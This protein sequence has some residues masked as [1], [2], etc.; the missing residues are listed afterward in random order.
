MTAP[1]PDLFTRHSLPKDA[2]A[3][4]KVEE[5]FSVAGRVVAGPAC[6]IDSP[7]SCLAFVHALARAPYN[8]TRVNALINN[9]SIQAPGP[10][11]TDDADEALTNDDLASIQP[12]AG[13]TP[14]STFDQGF[15]RV[16]HTNVNGT[17]FMTRALLPLL[18]QAAS[19]EDPARVLIVSSVMGISVGPFDSNFAYSASKAAAVH[20]SR[21]LASYFT[22]VAPIAVNALALG[23]FKTEMTEVITRNER[24]QEL[25]LGATVG[26]RE[27]HAQD[28]AA[29]VIYLLSRGGA[30]VNG[31]V[32]T[33]DG[34]FA[35]RSRV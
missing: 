11:A 13:L 8:V 7:A 28:L 3:D 20:L 14:G 16:M 9:A 12:A 27:A 35:L 29:A 23:Y 5:L 10:V 21:A 32:L 15:E 31:T 34:G 33:V 1:L 2:L 18:E 22:T 24:F 25:I 6:N 4:N 19:P 17:M 26:G 30:Y